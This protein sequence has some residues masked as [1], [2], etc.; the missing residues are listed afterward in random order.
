MARPTGIGQSSV[1][2]A[3]G[4]KEAEKQTIANRAK[5]NLAIETNTHTYVLGSEDIRK[6]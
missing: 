4:A 6:K 5:L 1:R 2:E 3:G